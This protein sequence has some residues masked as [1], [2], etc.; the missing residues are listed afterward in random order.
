MCTNPIKMKNK[1]YTPNSSNL[2]VIPKCPDGRLLWISA[3]CGVC[4]E[5][6]TLNA[7]TWRIRL[8][9]EYKTQRC[10]QFVTLTISDEMGKNIASEI[11]TEDS[12]E[13]AITMV[14][15]FRELWRKEFGRSPRR[16]LITELGHGNTYTDD[17]GRVR[18]GTHRLHLHG[19]IFEEIEKFGRLTWINQYNKREGRRSSTL[20]KLWRYGTSMIGHTDVNEK[21]INYILKYVTKSDTEHEGF[22]G[23]VLCSPGIGKEYVNKNRQKHEYR[24]ENTNKKY[25]H[26]DGRERGLPQYYRGKLWG[27]RTR[28][29]LRL[30]EEDK[31]TMW[32]NGYEISKTDYRMLAKA[33]IEAQNQQKKLK[34]YGVKKQK[35]T[36]VDGQIIAENLDVKNN[37]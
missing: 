25:K 24:G 13:I 8:H 3:P 33:I 26:I 14:R 30:I 17:R 1:R 31:P 20:S 23:R 27:T 10:G 29:K 37:Y 28:E 7:E 9:E 5:C 6:R 16:W 34:L 19:V 22:F 18:H 4:K 2:G 36:W 12:V 35:Y 11:G 32:Y 15:R 21:V